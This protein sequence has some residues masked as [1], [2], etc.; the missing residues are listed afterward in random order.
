MRGAN[1]RILSISVSKIF[2]CCPN[3]SLSTYH[4]FRILRRSWECLYLYFQ[5]I[6]RRR[7]LC[8]T[9]QEIIVDIDVRTDGVPTHYIQFCWSQYH[10]PSILLLPDFM[11]HRITNNRRIGIDKKRKS[12]AVSRHRFGLPRIVSVITITIDLI[13]IR[14]FRRAFG[15]FED[16]RGVVALTG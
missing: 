12:D 6:D 3:C 4:S 2:H 1:R 14:I 8:L 13:H 7:Y 9:N 11:N 16:C 10:K 5:S 15:V